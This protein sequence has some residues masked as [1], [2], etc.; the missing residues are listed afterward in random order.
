MQK[1]TKYICTTL[2]FMREETEIS[3]HRILVYVKKI[4]KVPAQLDL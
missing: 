3:L 2:A 4:L 1:E